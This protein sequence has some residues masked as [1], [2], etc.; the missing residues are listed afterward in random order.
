[1]ASTVA[2]VGPAEL[3][4]LTGKLCQVNLLVAP[5]F[6]LTIFVVILGEISSLL[7]FA[8]AVDFKYYVAVAIATFYVLLL[9]QTRLVD[10]QIYGMVVAPYK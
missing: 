1:M 3:D 7:P 9:Q 8:V 10:N 2:I 4:G 6:G 5:V